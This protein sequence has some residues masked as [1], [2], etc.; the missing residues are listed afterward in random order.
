MQANRDLQQEDLSFWWK[1]GV[2]LLMAF[3]FVVLICRAALEMS[4]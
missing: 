2:V 3:A 1:H 4:S